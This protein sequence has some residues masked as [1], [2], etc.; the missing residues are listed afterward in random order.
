MTK[1]NEPPE[2]DES[3]KINRL[4][5]LRDLAHWFQCKIEI[6]DGASAA[7]HKSFNFIKQL[8]KNSFK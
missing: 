8:I 6:D 1:S 7:E 2:Q 4:K 5:L 3:R